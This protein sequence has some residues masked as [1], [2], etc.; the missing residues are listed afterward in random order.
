MPIRELNKAKLTAISKNPAC[1]SHRTLVRY[2]LALVIGSKTVFSH[3][4]ERKMRFK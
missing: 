1:I 4:N 3:D 2:I